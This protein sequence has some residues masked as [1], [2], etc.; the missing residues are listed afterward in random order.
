M[1]WNS[2]YQN[3][4]LNEV[5]CADTADAALTGCNVTFINGKILC[6]FYWRKLFN[7]GGQIFNMLE[8]PYYIHR[9]T[10]HNILDFKTVP[11]RR[12]SK[13]DLYQEGDYERDGD[14][15]ADNS[16]ISVESLIGYHERTYTTGRRRLLIDVDAMDYEYEDTRFIK[17]HGVF[18][19]LAWIF[20]IPNA[21]FFARYFKESY[22]NVRIFQLDIWK[23]VHIGLNSLAG[24]FVLLGMIMIWV[25]NEQIK[26][27]AGYY[28]PGYTHMVVGYVTIALLPLQVLIG[29]LQLRLCIS[30]NNLYKKLTSSA[31]FLVGT[32]SY[33]L[34]LFLIA[35]AH[36]MI[37]SFLD[38]YD[39]LLIISWVIW[40]ALWHV[41]ISIHVF[42]QDRD[43]RLNTWRAFLPIP[44]VILTSKKVKGEFFRVNVFAFHASGAGIVSVLLIVPYLYSRTGC[45]CDDQ[46]CS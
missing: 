28:P 45:F 22:R 34:A 11:L 24:I 25:Y 13:R 10:G 31:H 23:I 12:R 26:Q 39:V 42:I 21:V 40:S 14:N 16:S 33:I 27:R 20:L 8:T 29:V 46:V 4:R 18:M 43:L 36:V 9:V 19:I 1:S 3:Y 37:T 32:L 6:N 7:V 41:V 15:D 44:F 38:C 2:G 35:R 17:L 30:S 5:S